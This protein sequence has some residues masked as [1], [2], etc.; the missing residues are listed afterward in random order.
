MK[1][2]RIGHIGVSH[3]HAGPVLNCVLSHSDVFEFIG[4]A[5]DNEENYQKK[6]V[7]DPVYSFHP[8]YTSEELIA[9]KPDAMLVEGYELENLDVALRCVEAGIHVHLDKPAGAD[10]A[11]FRRVLDVAKANG[12]C[13]HMGYMYRYNNAVRY[14]LDRVADGTIGEVYEVNAI[15]NTYHT[16]DKREWMQEFP[17]G[18]MFFLGCHMVDF[19]YLFMKRAPLAV[20]PFNRR[21][22]LDGVSV[23]D[24]GYAI[25]DYGTS[26]CT[27]VATST[28]VGGFARRQLVICGTKGTLELK[29]L[30]SYTEDW[31][32]YTVMKETL[33]EDWVKEGTVSQ[34]PPFDR[35]D[36]M[37]KN[38]AEI[39]RGER[40][41]PY[42]YDYELNLFR[43]IQKACGVC[44]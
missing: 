29:P 23:T 4:W 38:F 24:R 20:H 42:S 44:R 10:L 39:V 25:F 17:A 30:E 19:I 32:I 8:R 27:A 14:A 6:I 1:K 26:I 43:L 12:V 5:E 34:S 28:E 31:Q 2:I 40:E 3:D 22:E 15:M 36:G 35:Y 13:V 41:N 7:T 33:H 11:K 9:M 16:P 37:M 18:N 21:S